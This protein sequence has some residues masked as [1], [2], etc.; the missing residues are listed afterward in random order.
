[1]KESDKSRHLGIGIDTARYGHHAHFLREDRQLAAAPLP[2]A[3]SY[4]GYQQLVSR[5]EQLQQKHPNAHFHLRVDAAGQYANNLLAFL[6]ALELPMTLSVGEPKRNKDYHRAVS[7]KRKADASESLAMARF[8]VVERPGA[9]CLPSPEFLELR[10]VCGR[11]QAQVKQTTRVT[12]QLHN[13][14][15]GIFPELACLVSD[16]S[17][18]W[19]LHLL[20]KYPTPKK[21]AAARLSSLEK[22]PRIK[23]DLAEKIQHAAKNSVGTIRSSVS[24]GMVRELVAQ[25]RSSLKSEREL[26][27]MLAE[28]YGALPTGGHVHV[29]SI[30]G[31]GKTTA[32]ALVATMLTIERFESAKNLVGYYGVFPE[33]MSSGVDKYGNPH[34]PGKRRMCPKGND[35]VRSLLWNCAK[36]AI[37]CNPAVRSLY[38]RLRAKGVRGDVA[39]GY[40]MAKL[41]HLVFAVWKTNTPFNPNHYPWRHPDV[42]VSTPQESKTAAGHKGQSPN[43]KVV[44]AAKTS[45]ESSPQPVNQTTTCPSSTSEEVDF[46]A[47]RREVTMQQVLSHL[48]W[49]QNLRGGH[50]PGQL[51]GPCPVHGKQN[52]RSR[53]FSVNLDKHVF[54]CFNRDCQIAGNVLDLWAAVH[55]LPLREAALD[56]AATMHVHTRRTEKRNP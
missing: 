47:L 10:Q 54:Q 32:A 43:G 13:L 39:L 45:V 46:T 9:S 50:Q 20:D 17:H 38:K 42:E 7:P 29:P 31:I 11:L 49:L 25:L 44:T 30:L 12:N 40:C 1:M 15:S 33:E 2:F 27:K 21:L 55:R 5:L 3:E 16:L 14:L 23:S 35:L 37:R 6:R 48:G 19:V 52:S 36:A 8:A 28:A 18:R 22:I 26:E 34:P 4:E 53:S 41:L 24:E 51:R 56:L